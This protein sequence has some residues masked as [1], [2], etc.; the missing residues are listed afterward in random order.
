[1]TTDPAR[2][3]RDKAS[4]YHR[5]GAALDPTDAD[6]YLLWGVSDELRK[7]ADQLNGEG[8]QS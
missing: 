4:A 6:R 2:W 1:M 3:L 5:D 8:V 7:C